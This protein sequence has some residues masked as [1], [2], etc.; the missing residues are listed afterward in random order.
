MEVAKRS[1]RLWRAFHNILPCSANLRSRGVNCEVRCAR[2][3][4][5]DETGWHSLWSCDIA[6]LT[7]KGCSTWDK[8]P[9]CSARCFDGVCLF[10]ARLFSKEDV[11]IFASISWAIWWSRNVRVFQNLWKSPMEILEVVLTDRPPQWQPP[12]L[13]HLK[14]NVDAGCR[15]E[16]GF[17]G[18]GAVVRDSDGVVI[19]C[20]ARKLVGSFPPLTAEFLAL[21]EGLEFVAS[22]GVRVSEVETDALLV[23]QAI[24]TSD[25]PDDL[26]PIVYDIRALLQKVACGSPC[27]H[28]TCS[29]SPLKDLIPHG[30]WDDVC[31]LWFM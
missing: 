30:T 26:D 4:G 13:G 7:W 19:A 29:G 16:C 3:H 9:R 10:V 27:R 11:E 28:A 14:L 6:K 23:V 1:S 22:C 8:L 17:V 15:E 25:P 24:V 5:G 21:R 31:N 12:S 20:L 2:C 18:V